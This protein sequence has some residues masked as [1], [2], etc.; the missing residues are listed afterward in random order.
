M[1]ITFNNIYKTVLNDLKSD[2]SGLLKKVFAM[3]KKFNLI[4]SLLIL[5][6]IIFI[7]YNAYD[8]GNKSREAKY[9]MLINDLNRDTIDFTSWISNKK[10]I[11]DTAKDFVDNFSYDEITAGKTSN[12]YMNLNNDPDISQ[13]YIGL[14]TGEFITGGLWIPPEDYDP[15]NRVW[16]R[17]AVESRNTIISDVYFDRATGDRMVTISSPLHIDGT[18]AGVI[19]ADVFMN[20]ISN[21]LSNQITRNNIY[22]Y[23]LDPDGTI[24]VHTLRPELVG[25]NVYS[26]DRQDLP[27]IDNLKEFLEYF[28]EVRETSESVR[29]EYSVEGKKTLGIIRKIEE[30]NW[31]LAV[32]AVE[33]YD[34]CTFIK[35]NRNSLV[36]NILLLGIIILLLLLVIRIKLK[37][38]NK[39]KLL[40]L[41]NERDFLT[42]IY[43]RRYFD[44]YIDNICETAGGCSGISLV[45]MDIDFFKKYNDTYGHIRGDEVLRLVTN[46]VN[47]TIRKQDVFAR[48][49]GEEFVLVLE[50]VTEEIAQRIV[51]KV[52]KA[53]FDTGIEHS[54]SPFGRV[55]VSIGLAANTRRRIIDAH[56]FIQIADQALYKAKENGRNRVVVYSG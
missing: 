17:E 53:V 41:D 9:D 24:I 18:F 26:S 2:C 31:Y 20:D 44:L 27:V 34:L 50:D 46:A 51:E 42:G 12:P 22:T 33:D 30:G 1:F 28:E 54:S 49:G 15:R 19:S 6:I 47:H 48:Y 11:L 55:T 23:M 32:A 10:E 13:I 3:Y 21:W 37:L 56:H 52:L 5:T 29:M 39:N 8:L 4:I 25:E 45:M 35:Q 43:N 14:A 38:E 7:S 36:F 16:Y 40:T